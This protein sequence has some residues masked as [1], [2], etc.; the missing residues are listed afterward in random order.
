MPVV[1]NQS[2]RNRDSGDP[3]LRFLRTFQKVEDLQLFALSQH[4]RLD[5]QEAVAHAEGTRGP[6]VG[7]G[8]KP[9][10]FP[11]TVPC[12]GEVLSATVWD[13]KPTTE[14]LVLKRCRD[15]ANGTLIPPGSAQLPC[16]FGGHE[17]TRTPGTPARTA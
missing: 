13:R 6:I 2:S 9:E 4:P 14:T 16:R 7:A 17:R 10:I 12:S 3:I 8:S 5:I 11:F 1:H 15:Y